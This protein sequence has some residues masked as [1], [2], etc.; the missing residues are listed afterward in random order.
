MYKVITIPVLKDNYS[1]VIINKESKDAIIIDVPEFKPIYN[2]IKDNKLNLKYILLTHHHSDH[3]QGV[4]DLVAKTGAKVYG[5][6]IDKDR[7][8]KLDFELLAGQKYDLEGLNLDVIKSDGHTIGCLSFYFPQIN[9][10]FTGDLLF[11]MGCGRMF[12]GSY[13]VFFESLQ[14]IKKLPINTLIYSGHE[15]T[16]QNIEFA[17]TVVDISSDCLVELNNKIKSNIPTVPSLLKY[18]IKNNPFLIAK[19]VDEFATYRKL[20]DNF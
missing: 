20:K 17:E 11:T 14:K 15:Y 6:K 9:T 5:N 4:D 13:E 7:L 19:T 2:Y 3:I 16:K 8:P 1:Y 12:E 18:E 10:V